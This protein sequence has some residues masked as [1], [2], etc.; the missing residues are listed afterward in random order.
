MTL[1]KKEH[2]TGLQVHDCEI[3]SIAIANNLDLL[4]TFNTKDFEFIDEIKI[5]HV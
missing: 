3:A 5:H 2:I 4:A 1:L